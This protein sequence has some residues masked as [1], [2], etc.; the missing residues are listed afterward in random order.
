MK[1]IEV[2]AF[3]AKTHLSRLLDEVEHGAVVRITRRGK[4][5]AVLKADET[6]SREKGLETIQSIRSLC[7]DKMRL[8]TVLAFRDEGRER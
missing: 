2:G 4:V 6:V 1:T 5:V 3:E 8:Q 7:D